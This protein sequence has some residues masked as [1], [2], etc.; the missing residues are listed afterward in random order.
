MTTRHLLFTLL[1]VSA[2]LST[3]GTAYATSART[4]VEQGNRAYTAGEYANA[5]A[6]YEEAEVDLPESPRINFNRGLIF[7]RQEDYGKAKEAFKKAAPFPNPPTRLVNRKTLQIAFRFGFIFEILRSP[8]W[9]V[10][11]LK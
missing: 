4:L 8:R 7:Y 3:K 11:R 2:L 6:A 10:I 1:V 5:L 9:R